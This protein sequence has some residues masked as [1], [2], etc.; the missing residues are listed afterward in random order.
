MSELLHQKIFQQEYR[1]FSQTFKDHYYRTGLKYSSTPDPKI[2]DPTRWGQETRMQIEIATSSW[3]NKQA[4]KIKELR[5]IFL[6]DDLYTYQ[7]LYEK[8]LQSKFSFIFTYNPSN[9]KTLHEHFSRVKLNNLTLCK[10][11]PSKN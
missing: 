9:H 4:S 2:Y 10:P 11:I 3:L 7:P 6:S 1:I 5:P 8:I